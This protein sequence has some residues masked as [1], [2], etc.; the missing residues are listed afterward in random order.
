MVYGEREQGKVN[1]GE[2]SSQ[3]PKVPST[4]SASLSLG[5]FMLLAFLCDCIERCCRLGVAYCS[6]R[7]QTWLV[8]CSTWLP[9]S[10]STAVA[11][12]LSCKSDSA[13]FFR[14]SGGY[15]VGALGLRPAQPFLKHA[16]I[17]TVHVILT[18]IWAE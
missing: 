17:R 1:G 13:F 5:R 6:F 10:L 3:P 12:G 9:C 8:G 15:F 2:D 11:E 18:V 4:V 16:F 7:V 14:N